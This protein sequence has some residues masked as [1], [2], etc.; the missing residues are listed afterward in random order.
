MAISRPAYF[1]DVSD[2]EGVFVAPDLTVLSDD[3]S[4]RGNDLREVFNG[5]RYLVKIGVKIGAHWRLMPH[6]LP[7][8]EVVYQQTRRWLAAGCVERIVSAS[9]AHRQRLA[10]PAATA[11]RA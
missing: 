7:P 11:G 3:A 1:T 6:D 2:E 10:H 9:S 4:Q 5:L 8:W